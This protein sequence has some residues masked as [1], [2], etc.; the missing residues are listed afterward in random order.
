MGKNYLEYG[1]AGLVN[2][3]KPGSPYKGLNLKKNLSDLEK[4]EYEIMKLKLKTKD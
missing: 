2:A 1:E 4:L 3:K